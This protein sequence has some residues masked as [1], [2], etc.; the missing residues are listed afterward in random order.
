MTTQE[1]ANQLVALCREGKYEQ[2]YQELFSPDA[3]SIEPEG[4]GLPTAKGM[5]AIR[6]K[7]QQWQEMVEELYSS[8]ISDPIAADDFF[9]CTMKMKVKMK[10][11]E[12]PVNMDEVCVYRVK[13]GK[14]MSE[15]FFYTPEP[16]P[17]HS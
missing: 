7:G 12:E 9:S 14:V 13:N 3:E 10:G 6:Q 8:E 2:V 4:T 1:V 11:S 17:Q 16:A 5:D 15:Q